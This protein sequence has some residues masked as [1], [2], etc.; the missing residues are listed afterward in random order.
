MTDPKPSEIAA[1]ELN[2]EVDSP[3]TARIGVIQRITWRFIRSGFPRVAV[4]FLSGVAF[5]LVEVAKKT[6]ST[7]LVL[8]TFGSYFGFLVGLGAILIL[9]NSITVGLLVYYLQAL[10]ADYNYYYDRYRA[11]IADLRH[12][13][14]SLHDGGIISRAYDIPYR[15]I[16]SLMQDKYLSLN[17]HS[18]ALSFVDSIYEELRKKLRKREEFEWAYGNITTRLAVAEE[19]VNGIGLNLIQRIVLRTWLN[20]VTKSL[21]TLAMVILM[22]LVAIIHFSG[23][24]I[25]IL[26][27]LA[28]GVGCMT[29]LLLIEAGLNAIQETRGFFDTRTDTEHDDSRKVSARQA[30]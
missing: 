29:L 26:N 19:A 9:V 11:A 6:K 22:T 7:G 20:P 12:F 5:V 4:S 2:S 16:E 1:A 8:S 13:L 18:A 27:G 17:W 23:F 30:G 28:I 24:I 10:K 15:E 14:D 25:I 21:W 3:N